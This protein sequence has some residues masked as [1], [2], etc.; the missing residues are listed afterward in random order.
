[1]PVAILAELAF[2]KGL[3]L[4]RI[5]VVHEVFEE[6]VLRRGHDEDGVVVHPLPQEARYLVPA[7]IDVGQPA[8][9]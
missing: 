2:L 3:E 4:G 5:G 1:M 6:S 8:V 7:Q 9:A